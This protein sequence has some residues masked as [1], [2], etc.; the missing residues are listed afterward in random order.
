MPSTQ[1]LPTID[2]FLTAAKNSLRGESDSYGDKHSGSLYDHCAGPMAILF[3]REVEND[4]DQF[5]DIY[6]QDAT[7]EALTNLVEARWQIPRILSTSGTGTCTFQRSSTSAGGGTFWT[8]T[9]V[10]ISGKPPTVY[11]VAA[12]TVVPATST[13]ITVPIQAAVFGTGTAAN[14]GG[15]LSLLDPIYDPLWI[16]IQ[17][18][19]VDGTDF[20][21]ANDFRARVLAQQLNSRNGYIPELVATC[22]AAGATYVVAFA[23]QYGLTNNSDGFAGDFG[24]NAIYVA[25]ANF[26]GTDT[27]ALLCDVALESSRV[28]GADLWVGTISQSPLFVQATVALID[29]PGRLDVLPIQRACTQALLN[30]FGS[31]ASGYTYKRDAMAGAMR[32]AHPAVQQVVSWGSPTADVTLA[33]TNWPATLTR[34]TLAPRSIFLNFVGPQ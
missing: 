10:Q 18:Q 31:T 7:S 15:G 24:L 27:L 28:L 5:K 14:V 20:E 8:G 29:Q 33:P 16:P 4:A 3:S 23:S 6:F 12:D 21:A 25:D 34:W 26:Q 22:Q 11:Q 30:Y 1:T 2:E 19:C 32:S 17:L 9:R 13:V